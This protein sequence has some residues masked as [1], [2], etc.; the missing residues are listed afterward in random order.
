MDA[1]CREHDTAYSPSKDFTKRHIADKIL[2]EEARKLI[3]AKDSTL[4]ERESSCYNYSAAMKAKTKIGMGL[5][6]KKKK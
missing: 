1:A 3:T 6:M 4:R 2:V 5:K